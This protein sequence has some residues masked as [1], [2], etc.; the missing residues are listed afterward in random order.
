MKKEIDMNK[1]EIIK[2]I[3]RQMMAFLLLLIIT[4]IGFLYLSN[5][6]SEL[7]RRI[8]TIEHEL[9]YTKGRIENLEKNQ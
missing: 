4:V 9:D 6:I 1:D 7:E 8:R 5:Q 3:R 2:I